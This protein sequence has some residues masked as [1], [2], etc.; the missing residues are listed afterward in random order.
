MK[1]AVALCSALVLSLAFSLTAMAAPSVDTGAVA[2]DG[3]AY[4]QEITNQYAATTTVTSTV[5]NVVVSAVSPQTAAAANNL[6][7]GYVGSTAV[8]SK[9]VD[10]SVPEG[11]GAAEFTLTDANLLAGMNVTI[12]HQKADGNWEAITPSN[13]SNGSVTF[14]LT[15]YSPV[16]IV[17]NAVAP[18]T[19][20][21]SVYVAVLAFLCLSGTCV[22]LKKAY[23]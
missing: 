19:G 17:I 6:A 2:E 23:M 3:T 12:L 4:T 9:V 5:A 15:A 7:K 1:K 14:T 22:A 20:D 8:V 13:V 16:A 18:K 11:T 10:I 21:M